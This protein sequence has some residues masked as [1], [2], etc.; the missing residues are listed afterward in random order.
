MPNCW[1]DV[2]QLEAGNNGSELE[3]DHYELE[4]VDVDVSSCQWLGSP[5]TLDNSLG[6]GNV[7]PETQ[8]HAE[9]TSSEE[10]GVSSRVEVGDSW[11]GKTK[12]DFPGGRVGSN[13]D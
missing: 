5:S 7:K 6:P 13:V 12:G 8:L 4:G 1:V 2:K 3:E 11:D 9:S 10:T